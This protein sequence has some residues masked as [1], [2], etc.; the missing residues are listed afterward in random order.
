MMEERK[1]ILGFS[2]VFLIIASV[3]FYFYVNSGEN[4]K[5]AVIFWAS[6]TILFSLFGI[7]IVSVYVDYIG[8]RKKLKEN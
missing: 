6:L 1:F 2:F 4:Y 3:L 7:I 5:M 8:K